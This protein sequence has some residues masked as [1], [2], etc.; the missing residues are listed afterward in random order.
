MAKEQSK[1]DRIDRIEEAEAGSAADEFPSDAQENT[2]F[3][4]QRTD[5]DSDSPE[6]EASEQEKFRPV[7]PKIGESKDTLKQRSKWFQ[8]R[9]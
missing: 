9:H 3:E 4:E 7:K 8:K 6:E 5:S 1:K 2:D